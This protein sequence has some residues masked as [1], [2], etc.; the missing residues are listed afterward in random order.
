[1]A[2]IKFEFDIGDSVLIKGVNV[3]GRIVGVYYGETGCQYQTSYFYDG[4]NKREYI[5]GF[6]LQLLSKTNKNKFGFIKD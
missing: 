2:T 4:N 5:Y 6:D 3:E 1:M